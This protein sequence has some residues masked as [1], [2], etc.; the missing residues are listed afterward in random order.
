MRAHPP[1][2]LRNRHFLALDALLLPLATFAAFA[3]RFEGL[4]W[5]PGYALVAAWFVALSLPI[6]MG[7]ALAAGLYRRVWRHA[8]VHEAEQILAAAVVLLA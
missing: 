2:G 3:I 6:K 8:S 4:T 7:V 1:A 5:P